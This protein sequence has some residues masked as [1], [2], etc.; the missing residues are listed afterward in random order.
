MNDVSAHVHAD[1]HIRDATGIRHIYIPNTGGMTENRARILGITG[2][3]GAGKSTAEDFF[4]ARGVP[5]ADADACAHAILDTPAV[6]SRIYT[7]FRDHHHC[8]VRH[9]GKINRHLLATIVFSDPAALR[10]VEDVIHP[11]VKDALQ[12]WCDAQRDQAH[13]LAVISVPLL[14][15]SDMA[16]MVDALVLITAPPALRCARVMRQRGWSEDECMQRMR[17]QMPDEEKRK[18]ADYVI[19]NN[20]TRDAFHRA[21]SDVLAAEKR[22]IM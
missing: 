1:I 17:R 14:I 15:E 12:A 20:G 18:Y 5:V 8:D 22:A 21:L 4:R 11:Q 16:D 13:A 2:G 3:L 10:F 6:Q 7:Y 19:E 9:E